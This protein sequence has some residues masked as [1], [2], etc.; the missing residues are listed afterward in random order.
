MFK[1]CSKVFATSSDV[2]I[3]ISGQPLLLQT[4][5]FDRLNNLRFTPSGCNDTAIRKF[6]WEKTPVL[7]S[8]FCFDLRKLK[9]QVCE[10]YL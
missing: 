8:F 5:N 10:S 3:P 9:T 1:T 6:Q 4:I 7:S 2:K